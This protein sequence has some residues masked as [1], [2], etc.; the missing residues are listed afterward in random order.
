MHDHIAHYWI[1]IKKQIN[2]RS[3]RERVLLFVTGIVVIWSFM[4]NIFITP[5][6]EH[7][8]DSSEEL[9]NLE[10]QYQGTNHELALLQD[11]LKK[12]TLPIQSTE[13]QQLE[14]I[15]KEHNKILSQYR[16]K[17]MVPEQAPYLLE[18]LLKDFS[19][20][21]LLN[22]ETLPPRQ[23]GQE[24]G[25]NNST[26][27]LYRQ[28]IR[29]TFSGEYQDLLNYV[30][31]IETLTYP[32]WWEDIEYKVTQFPQAQIILTVYTLSEHANWIGV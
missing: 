27:A 2:V 30:R 12:Q 1:I 5:T 10:Q 4:F 32:I 26:A 20:L 17:L 22:I 11:K 18:K 8:A 7:I 3:L 19:G 6:S 16:E 13:H 21:V 25:K 24:A 9:L 28:A 31:K 15:L 29:L 23:L 14:A